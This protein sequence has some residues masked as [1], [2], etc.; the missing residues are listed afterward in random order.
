MSPNPTGFRRPKLQQQ[1]L[2]PLT[3]RFDCTGYCGGICGDA[4][5]RG[6]LVYT[7]R[8][9]RLRSDEP[10]PDPDSPGMNL[11]QVDVA[12]YKLSGGA[13][14]LDTHYRYPIATA[15]RRIIEGQ[16]AIVQ[17]RN[18]VLVDR[19]YG[20][21]KFRNGHAIVVGYDQIRKVPLIGN[22]LE[23]QFEE[24]R[25]ED[26]WA[27]AAELVVGFDEGHAIVC[28]KGKT[29]I[30]FTRDV[31]TAPQAPPPAPKVWN[32]L[33]T[34]GSFWLYAVDSKLN[35]V[36]RVSKSFDKKTS[37]PSSA[38]RR[39]PWPAQKSSRRLAR[40]NNG[41]LLGRYVDPD[42]SGKHVKV[43]SK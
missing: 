15:Q 20:K 9:I 38:P 12:L 33:F 11:L 34:P 28:G 13:I 2:E 14:D 7:G 42:D 36:G 1:L 25:W 26:I 17:V 5:T 8:Q 35:I 37:A 10:V 43:V 21:N 31:Y 27:A 23:A 19:G 3:G 40:I 32:A 16:W 29:Y 24:A 30:A 39:Y 22:P 41:P 4:D 18:G 6:I